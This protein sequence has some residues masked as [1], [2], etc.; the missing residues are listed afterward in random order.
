MKTFMRAVLGTAIIV[1]A[2]A[3]SLSAQRRIR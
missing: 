3:T 2:L 1:L